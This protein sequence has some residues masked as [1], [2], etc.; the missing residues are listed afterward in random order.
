MKEK[1]EKADLQHAQPGVLPSPQGKAD[2]HQAFDFKSARF[3]FDS[4][5]FTYTFLLH[6]EASSIHFD[7]QRGEIFYKG[8]NLRNMT[9]SE[10]QAK[11][12]KRMPSLLTQEGQG[13]LAEQYKLCLL[14]FLPGA[15]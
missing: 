11:A 13:V 7:A 15:G 6:G 10:A 14:K 9:P 4:H 1:P 12:L 5:R 2:F 8:H 3:F